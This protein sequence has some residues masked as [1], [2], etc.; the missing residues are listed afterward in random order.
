VKL[1]M[2]AVAALAPPPPPVEK[3]PPPP[4]PVVVEAPKPVVEAPKPPPATVA[5]APKPPTD[6]PTAPPPPPKSSVSSLAPDDLGPLAERPRSG[7]R[8]FGR[9]DEGQGIGK[10]LTLVAGG[11]SVVGLGVGVGFGLMANA[12]ATTLV[13]GA[14]RSQ[15]DVNELYGRAQ[16]SAMGANIGYATAAGA[17]VIAAIL[18]FVEQPPQAAEE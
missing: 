6:R 1:E 14:V 8:G 2:A 10:P 16:S 5:A 7:S 3:A 12:A 18:F 17:A 11:A 9:Q 15:T 13:D 4:P